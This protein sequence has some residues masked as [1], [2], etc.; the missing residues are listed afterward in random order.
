L[1]NIPQADTIKVG[2]VGNAMSNS[3]Y[4][5]RNYQPADFDKY[6]LLHAEAEKLEPTG[7]C[8]LRQF[9]AEQLRR[10]NYHP[11]QDLFIVGIGEDIVGYMDV[12]PELTIRR[13]VL[14]CWVF[15]EHRKRE[16]TTE[17]FSISM[18]RAKKLGAKVAHVNI[19]EDNV[20]VKKVLLELGFSL[21][22]RFLE[23]RLDIGHVDRLDVHPNIEC[24][25]L[26]PGE[27]DKLTRLQNCAFAG[28]WGYNHNTVEEI[29]FRIKT[30]T[31]S[32]EDIV[33]TYEGDKAI[34][35]CWTGIS[36]E[37]G[38]PSV[39]KGRIH[40]LG[41][42]PGYRGKG[43]GRGLAIAGLTRLRNRGLQVAELTVDS[44]NRT[45]RAL[46]QSLGFEVQANTFWYE[47]VIT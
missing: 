17:L 43:V 4:T 15:P 25:Y 37:E 9:I 16:L 32:R 41:V 44:E 33:L 47:K 39:R 38:I 23:L 7:R 8:V 30:S 36:C 3:I 14:D 12:K 5:I 29:A 45:A 2:D 19:N 46:Y 31:C 40:M 1:Y 20:A 22:R 13:V 35:C 28:T 27:E 6:I 10:P 18:N 11:E 21:V 24:Y 26:R 42:A 34:G